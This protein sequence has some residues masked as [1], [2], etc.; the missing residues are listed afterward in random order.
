MGKSAREREREEEEGERGKLKEGAEH[1]EK[2]QQHYGAAVHSV[3]K[4]EA[5]ALVA[6]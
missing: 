2:A 5:E 3:L 1:A 6:E 4:T